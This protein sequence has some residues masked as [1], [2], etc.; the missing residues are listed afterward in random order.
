MAPARNEP[1][2][3]PRGNPARSGNPARRAAA[4]AQP[5]SPGR[6]S[7]ER[8]SRPWL[9]RLSSIPRWLLL[10]ITLAVLL[11]GLFL[12]GVAGGVFLLVLA[13]F[14]GWLAVLSWPALGIW[15]R[16]LRAATVV[17]VVAVGVTKILEG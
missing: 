13:A 1:S 2:P 17:L 7:L 5:S 15:P 8:A 16:V 14:L 4:A 12:P 10:V 6:S 11:A 3:R 9:V